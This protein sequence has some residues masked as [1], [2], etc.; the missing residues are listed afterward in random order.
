M[1]ERKPEEDQCI[2]SI[3]N[4]VRILSSED[5]GS[6]SPRVRFEIASAALRTAWWSGHLACRKNEDK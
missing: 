5:F 3:R 6:Y 2:K 1:I 4:W